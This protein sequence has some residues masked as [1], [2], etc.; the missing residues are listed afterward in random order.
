MTEP[1]T[2]PGGDSAT[3]KPARYQG[4]RVWCPYVAGNPFHIWT[5]QEV[6]AL[7]AGGITHVLPIVVPPQDQ[8]WWRDNY[9]YAA[10]ELL[11][12]RALD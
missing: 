3:P 11:V 7:A 10:L 12:R 1:A 5:R 4:H 6:R 2:F 8:E 9:G